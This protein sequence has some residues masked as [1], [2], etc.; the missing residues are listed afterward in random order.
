M[1]GDKMGRYLAF[2]SFILHIFNKAGYTI[3]DPGEE[4]SVDFIAKTEKCSYAVEVKYSPNLLNNSQ[5][6]ISR[7][8]GRMTSFSERMKMVP[9]L[10]VASIVDEKQRRKFHDTY[11]KIQII[12]VPNL[13]FEIPLESSER[14]EFI[15]LLPFAID[16][17]EP[18]KGDINLSWI[19][20]NDQTFALIKEIEDCP[21]GQKGAT[22][23]EKVCTKVLKYLF[24]DDLALW[25]E[26]SKSNNDL[27]RFDLLCRVKNG[28][29]S[30]FWSIVEHYFNSK[31]LIFEFKNYTDK[32]TQ[33]EVYTTEKYLYAKAL[34]S[35]GIIISTNGADNH[36]KW[37]TKGLLRES[38][39]LIILLSKND[40]IEM[41]KMK[42]DDEDPSEYLLQILD[43]LLLELEK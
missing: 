24:S 2:E 25:R 7:S 42:K 11:K 43:D 29:Q 32:I 26:Q 22:Q 28:T 39:K 8:L 33:K 9:I 20:H 30:T 31:Y 34:R 13:L 14:D 36:A 23:Y 27:Y 16:G 35:V 37:A 4:N 12:D 10:V 1:D 3:E 21:T 38:G 15:S 17:I 40:L 18:Q 5:F 6:H 19:V 41:C